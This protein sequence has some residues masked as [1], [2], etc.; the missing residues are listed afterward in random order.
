[1]TG[2]S[3]TYLEAKKELDPPMWASKVR[4][5]PYSYHMRTVCMRVELYG[6]L[7]TGKLIF[8]YLFE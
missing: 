8:F 2:N 5:L 1:M 7:W 4:F 6:C 3:N